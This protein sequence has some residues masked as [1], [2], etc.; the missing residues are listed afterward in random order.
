MKKKAG[1]TLSELLIVVAIIGVLVAVSIPIFTQQLHKAEVATDWA[2]VRSY[3]AQLQY[4]FMETGKVNDTYLHEISMQPTGL[5]SFNLAGQTVNLK[6]GS[7]WVAPEDDKNERGYNLLYIC[8]EGNLAHPECTLLLP[9]DPP[10]EG[11]T[12]YR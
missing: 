12:K 6:A 10:S 1:F 5:T 3:Y 8:K 2:N 4:D 11:G 9:E 7:L